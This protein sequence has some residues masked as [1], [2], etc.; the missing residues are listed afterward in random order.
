MRKKL[1]EQLVALVREGTDILRRKPPRLLAPEEHELV[2]A[3][4]RLFLE[5]DR[6]ERSNEVASA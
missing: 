1:F 5:L 2:Y 6:R 3:A 4:D